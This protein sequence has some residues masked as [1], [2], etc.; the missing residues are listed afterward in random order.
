MRFAAAYSEHPVAADAAGEVIGRIAELGGTHPDLVIVFSGAAHS[1]FLGEMTNAVRNVLHPSVLLGVA[2]HSVVGERRESEGRAAVSVWASWNG[3]VQPVRLGLDP[4]AGQAGEIAV[5][6]MPDEVARGA[7]LVLLADSDSF[8]AESLIDELAQT[9]PDV[10]VVGG[11]VPSPDKGRCTLIVD[12]RSYSDGAIGVLIPLDQLV[13][14]VVSQGCRPVGEPMVV[15]S[16]RGTYVIELDDR[17]ALERLRGLVAEADDYTRARLA[18]GVHIGIATGGRRDRDGS[19]DYLVRALLGADRARG[20]IAVGGGVQVGSIVRFHVSD[21]VAASDHLHGALSG[22]GGD[23]A[24]IFT[25]VGRGQ[26]MFGGQ[27]HD[28]DLV[29]EVIETEA[30]AGMFCAGEFGPVGGRSYLH[31]FAASV[32]VFAAADGR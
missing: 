12:D 7:T 24:L 16:A 28:A 8:P 23:A 6:G 1:Q 13:G 15:T 26:A 32:L 5:S 25:C 22:I 21:A 19:E 3:P 17:P 31:S 4:E 27:D 30:I 29:A 14:P 18:D 9:R 11:L 10:T 20:V 2:A